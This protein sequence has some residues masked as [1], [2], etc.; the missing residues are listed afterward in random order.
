MEPK[1]SQSFYICINIRVFT[2]SYILY[3]VHHYY[4][5]GL[6]LYTVQKGVGCRGHD[7]M[8]V[9]FTR[10]NGAYHH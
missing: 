9:R 3:I 5:F 7:R 8:V 1:R 2:S 6:L 10:V 4:L